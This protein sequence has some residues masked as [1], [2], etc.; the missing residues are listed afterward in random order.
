MPTFR[1]VFDAFIFFVFSAV[2][3]LILHMSNKSIEPFAEDELIFTHRAESANSATGMLFS[4]DVIRHFGAER[5]CSQLDSTDVPIRVLEPQ[6]RKWNVVTTIFN[7]TDAVHTA[8]AV[9]GWCTVIVGDRKTPVSYMEDSNLGS[10]ENVFF[11]WAEMQEAQARD[12]FGHVVLFFSIEF[13]G[14]GLCTFIGLFCDLL[15]VPRRLFHG[16]RPKAHWQRVS[17]SQY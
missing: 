2:C 7:V 10:L 5:A 16:S 13:G 8:A 12:R 3:L 9:P 6:C 4:G 1:R 11:L 15:S 14:L 17:R